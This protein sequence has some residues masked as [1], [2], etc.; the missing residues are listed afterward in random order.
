M[1]SN[2]KMIGDPQYYIFTPFGVGIQ[3]WI[4]SVC[5]I[6]H[7][8]LRSLIESVVMLREST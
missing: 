3:C 1:Y 6:Q 2:I 5:G 8:G 7:H 4:E